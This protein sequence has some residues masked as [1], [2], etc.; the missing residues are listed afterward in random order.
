MHAS[1]CHICASVYLTQSCTCRPSVP[2][3]NHMTVGKRN[4]FQCTRTSIIWS[5]NVYYRIS[6]TSA[7]AG[8]IL[9]YRPTVETGQV[10]QERNGW[11]YTFL[12]CHYGHSP[13]ERECRPVFVRTFVISCL[14]KLSLCLLAVMCG[15]DLG[16]LIWT[17][18]LENRV[19]HVNTTLYTGPLLQRPEPCRL[20]AT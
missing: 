9:I 17:T 12:Y 13:A 4:S 5:V 19:V 14:N 3:T 16:Q 18:F 2:N 11:M 8:S 10:V 7:G 6:S 20:P 1:P 15:S